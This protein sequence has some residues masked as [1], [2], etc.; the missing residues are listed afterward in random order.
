[1][2]VII[3]G[4]EQTISPGMTLSDLLAARKA[5]PRRVAIEVNK[6][7]VFRADYEKTTINEGD[8]IEIVTFVGGG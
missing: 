7:L 4:E 1:M 5:E 6:E 8:R 3:N 2:Q